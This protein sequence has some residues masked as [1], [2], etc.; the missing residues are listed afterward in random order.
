MS[1]MCRGMVYTDAMNTCLIHGLNPFTSLHQDH[2]EGSWGPTDD[3]YSGAI[4]QQELLKIQS[5][6]WTRALLVDLLSSWAHKKVRRETYMLESQSYRLNDGC[7]V[8]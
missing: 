6:L 1:H 8:C 5:C 7:H 2:Q 3:L 4:E